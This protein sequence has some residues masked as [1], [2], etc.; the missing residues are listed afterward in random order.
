MARIDE[1][2]VIPSETPDVNQLLTET[3]FLGFFVA[4]EEYIIDIMVIQEIISPVPVTYIPRM[5]GYVGG[6]ITLRGEIIPLFDLRKR[7]NLI[8]GEVNKDSRIIVT[9]LSKGGAG[10]VVDSVT[11]VIRIVRTEIEP[12]PC[13]VTEKEGEFIKGIGKYKGRMVIQLDFERALSI[14]NK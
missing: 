5:P 13:N 12:P 2:P 3:E 1:P 14:D 11:E 4:G 8:A 6:I 7:L 10:M 9:S